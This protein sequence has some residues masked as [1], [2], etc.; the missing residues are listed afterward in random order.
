MQMST[1][2]WRIG[3]LCGVLAA[4]AFA[5]P[6]VMATRSATPSSASALDDIV[7][8]QK[9]SGSYLQYQPG[10]AS[11]GSGVITQSIATGS[12]GC[13]N[14]M[15]QGTPVLSF[16]AAYYTSGYPP[17]GGVANP[18]NAFPGLYN[19]RAG[20]GCDGNSGQAWA[21]EPGEDLIFH[22]GSSTAT[23]NRLFSSASIPVQNNDGKNPSS[24]Q[25]VLSVNGSQVKVVPFTIATGA[26]STV[27]TGPV[28]T[29][30]D[31]L[32][33]EV[34]GSSGTVSVVG[35]TQASP[36]VP[37]F[38]LAGQICAGQTIT[39]TATSSTYGT[40]TASITSAVTNTACK[41]YTD[42]SATFGSGTSRSIN[43]SATG[44][45]PMKFTAHFDWGDFPLC[46]PGPGT[47]P[48]NECGYTTINGQPETFCNAAST[49]TPWCATNVDYRDD[50]SSTTNIV[51]DWSGLADSSWGHS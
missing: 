34:P 30:F 32:E 39:T 45:T 1:R 42:F 25:L 26:Q 43:F 46:S 49:A 33:V 28:S 19:L 23:A 47:T 12:G 27:L 20:V 16:S 2:K 24:G 14:P 35:P 50:S 22:I 13:S 31:Q 15:I 51:E 4:F 6:I 7:F 48:S 37:T 3:A 40:V 18:P 10:G 38:Y 5:V 41:T 9:K 21:V 36:D 8:S 17:V 29:G 44:S 11:T